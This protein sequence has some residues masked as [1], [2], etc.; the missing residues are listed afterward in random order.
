MIKLFP[1]QSHGSRGRPSSGRRG[2]GR[3]GGKR[4]STYVAVRETEDSDDEELESEDPEEEEPTD[5]E[6]DSEDDSES[7]EEET[8]TEDE[9]EW[10]DDERVQDRVEEA[11]AFLTEARNRNFD[12]M[13]AFETAKKR[14]APARKARGFRATGEQARDSGERDKEIKE[15]M[16]DSECFRCYERGHWSRECPYDSDEAERKRRKG[17]KPKARKLGGTRTGRGRSTS[18]A[19]GGRRPNRRSRDSKGRYKNQK[20]AKGGKSGGQRRKKKKVRRVRK[21][22]AVYAV[23]MNLREKRERGI[24][25]RRPD[26]QTLEAVL[27]PGCQRTVAGWQTLKPVVEKLRTDGFAVPWLPDTNVFKFGDGKKRRS[28]GKLLL[29]MQLDDRQMAI[30]VSVVRG[31]CPLLLSSKWHAKYDLTVRHRDSTASSP[32]SGWSSGA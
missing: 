31:A 9:E 3:W 26:A 14:R 27:D 12:V 11:A 8:Q 15:A 4:R 23:A 21:V 17:K 1:R 25:M 24:R 29:P 18:R 10:S 30:S 2:G 22:G 20:G 7:G 6:E 16:K 5:D 13:A 28:M 32:I 19:T